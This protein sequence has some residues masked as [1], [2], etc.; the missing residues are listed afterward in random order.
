MVCSIL[1]IVAPRSER[2][3]S[4][5]TKAPSIAVIILFE[6]D[7]VNT[8]S[9]E[10]DMRSADDGL[11]ENNPPGLVIAPV[12]VVELLIVKVT[13]FEEPELPSNA[14]DTVSVSP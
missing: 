5:L 12:L 9:S 3:K 13:L 8:S 7:T 10:T 1:D 4:I 14:S 2:S 6:F 11:P